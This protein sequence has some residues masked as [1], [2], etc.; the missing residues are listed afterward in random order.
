LN[1]IDR[2]LRVVSAAPAAK[3]WLA[4]TQQAHVLYSFQAV[5]DLIN[6]DGDVLALVAKQIGDGPFSLVL[7]PDSFPEAVE[8]E[9][10]LLV[11][12]NGFWLGD[13]LID[14]ENAAAWE[15]KPDW[16]LV[17]TK[18]A[19]LAWAASQLRDLLQAEAPED[20]IARLILDPTYISPL[21][22]RIFQAAEQNLPL[23]FSGLGENDQAKVVE[24]SK[25]LAGLGPGLTPAGDDVLLGVMYGLWATRGEDAADTAQRIAN[26]A[27]PRTHALSG[28][29]LTACTRGEAASLWH[30]LLA[31]IVQKNG[32]QVKDVAMRILPTG[33]TS[34]ADALGGF[35][36]MIESQR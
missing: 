36:G 5:A 33:H 12:E 27:V 17:R 9:T 10:P 13:S 28:A 15:P 31:A 32:A 30:R 24:A 7:E 20:S 23:L 21:P 18:P 35:L 19:E 8:I 25:K 4:A 26:A 22:A 6:Q 34:G 14:A 29:W 16:E 3:A 11:F 1:S 2:R